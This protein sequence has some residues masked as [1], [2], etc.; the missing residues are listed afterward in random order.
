MTRHL[1]HFN[2]AR[3]AWSVDDPRVAGFLK[4]RDPIRRI[5]EASPGFVWKQEAGAGEGTEAGDPGLL[6]SLSVWESV[7]ALAHFSW[8]TLH[9]R[10]W[11]KRA[12]WFEPNEGTNFAMWWVPRGHRPSY[13]EAWD[14]I[15]RR[16]RNGDSDEAFGWDWVSLRSRAQQQPQAAG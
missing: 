6:L 3:L 2:F 15:G 4:G 9:K 1:A 12:E 8:N 13:D 14:R 11:M 10:F 16:E 7:E 5:A